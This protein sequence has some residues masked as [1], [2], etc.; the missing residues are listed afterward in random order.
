MDRIEPLE[1]ALSVMR[2]HRTDRNERILGRLVDMGLDINMKDIESEASG[3]VVARPHFA[4]ALVKKRYARDTSDAFARYLSRGAPAYVARE[5]LSPAECVS[6]IRETGGL[7]V[8]AHP[9]LIGLDA[10]GLGDFLE[11]LK[12]FGLWGLECISSHCSSQ[13]AYG[14]LSIAEKHDLFPTAG[15]DF[16]GSIRP[17]ASLGVQVSDDF[18]PW[19]RLGVAF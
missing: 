2:A 18:L 3:R 17:N 5:G 11:D 15:S 19:A 10:D 13:E 9:S 7:P 8:L 1:D 6:V 4:S 16:H 12:Q 14:F